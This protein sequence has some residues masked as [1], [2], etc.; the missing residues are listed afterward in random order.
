M[1]Y[2]RNCKFREVQLEM[3]REECEFD[4]R[5]TCT[6]HVTRDP[7]DGHRTIHLEYCPVKNNDLK[8]KDWKPKPIKRNFL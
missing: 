6:K 7:Y 1:P 5:Q 8:C 4:D 2:C 3:G